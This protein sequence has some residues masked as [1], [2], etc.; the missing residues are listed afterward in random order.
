MIVAQLVSMGFGQ[1]AS[2]KAV[3]GS[4]NKNADAAMDYGFTNGLLGMG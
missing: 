3:L 1:E 2:E 4:G